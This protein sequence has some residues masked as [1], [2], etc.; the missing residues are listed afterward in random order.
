MVAMNNKRAIE[1]YHEHELVCEASPAP[2]GWY[3]TIS[4]VSHNG[5]RSEAQTERSASSYSSDLEAL[6]AARQ[7]GHALID[8]LIAG[9][10]RA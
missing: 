7:R 3:Y 1:H 4:V 6:H 10:K 5:D 9:N 2:H 8:E